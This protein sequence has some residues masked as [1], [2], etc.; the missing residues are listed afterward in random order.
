MQL[1]ANKVEDCNR[2]SPSVYHYIS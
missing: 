2:I 1:L